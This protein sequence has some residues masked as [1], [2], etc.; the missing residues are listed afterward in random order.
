MF[1]SHK[2]N[3]SN[4]KVGDNTFTVLKMNSLATLTPA[5]ISKNAIDY[6]LNAYTTYTI[7]AILVFNTE[8]GA[9][10]LN[11]LTSH[12]YLMPTIGEYQS[13]AKS[14]DSFSHALI[15]SI[16]QK[17]NVNS[18]HA[19]AK[20][21]IGTLL[22][23]VKN[24][25]NK[26]RSVCIHIGHVGTQVFSNITV[27]NRIH[28]QY[29]Q[30]DK[31][32]DVLNAINAA[33]GFS[34]SF[35]FHSLD[36]VIQKSHAI[37]SSV[38]KDITLEGK[39]EFVSQLTVAAFA[40]KDAFRHY[41][42]VSK[43]TVGQIQKSAIENFVYLAPSET[44]LCIFSLMDDQSI[45]AFLLSSTILSVI[46]HK[47]D[48]IWKLLMSPR[49]DMQRNK[50]LS[51]ENYFSIWQK[52]RTLTIQSFHYRNNESHNQIHYKNT[53]MEL[54]KKLIIQDDAYGLVCAAS[55]I[56]DLL[57]AIL[58]NDLAIGSVVKFEIDKNLKNLKNET[59]ITMDFHFI[60]HLMPVIIDLH[61]HSCFETF[62]RTF[63]FGLEV[64]NQSDFAG[65]ASFENLNEIIF[66]TGK[67][68]FISKFIE[69]TFKYSNNHDFL[70]QIILAAV[71]NKFVDALKEGLVFVDQK[72]YKF[73]RLLFDAKLMAIFNQ[74]G[75][76]MRYKLEEK[77]HQL[78]DKFT[79]V[80][81][82]IQ[83][84]VFGNTISPEDLRELLD[85]SFQLGLKVMSARKELDELIVP[86]HAEQ[87][88][89]NIRSLSF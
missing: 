1:T 4:I 77:W 17:F 78:K 31:I 59:I 23:S 62:L 29:D 15:K 18:A 6:P 55:R 84:G 57:P 79:N 89:E 45:L 46:L 20:K 42:P 48:R 49:F 3:H 22:T 12:G 56:G 72:S 54:I 43:N 2:T 11:E 47:E 71:E 21:I 52:Q 87:E 63:Y 74:C 9:F 53:D 73:N 8:K 34:S 44:L 83:S 30:L 86:S 80:Q 66:D 41:K 32:I 39:N 81:V 51:D 14:S 64:Y 26:P 75:F 58:D 67:P 16:Q 69:L 35:A 68:H 27:L 25:N 33:N 76:D 85:Q 36:A 28:T 70:K 5:E 82:R 50:Y 13:S 19:E 40:K 38:V 61:A 88:Q 60:H 37:S 10:V 65:R 7:S 24:E